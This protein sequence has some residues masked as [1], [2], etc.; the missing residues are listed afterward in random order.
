MRPAI[1][2]KTW[3][4]HNAIFLTHALLLTT[5]LLLHCNP[6]LAHPTLLHYLFQH[7]CIY[8][9]IVLSSVYLRQF[10]MIATPTYFHHVM[11][12]IRLVWK[13]YI[14]TI[15]FGMLNKLNKVYSHHTTFQP[16]SHLDSCPLWLAP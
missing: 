10:K 3:S 2:W 15:R 4:P 9:V 16:D 7:C 11:N 6:C 1:D 8:I 5:Q 14:N 12:L 13:I